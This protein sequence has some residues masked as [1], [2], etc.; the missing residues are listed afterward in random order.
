MGGGGS[1]PRPIQATSQ[2]QANHNKVIDQSRDSNSLLQFNWASFGSGVSS[3]TIIGVLLVLLFFC[4]RYNKRA[5][6]KQH[7]AQ[8]HEFAAITGHGPP[9]G[10][11][12]SSRNRYRDR[13]SYP[14]GSGYP[15]NPPP[16]GYSNGPGFPGSPPPGYSGYS[17]A[18]PFTA[19]PPSTIPGPHFGSLGYQPVPQ[20]PQFSTAQLSAALSSLGSMATLAAPSEDWHRLREVTHP[21]TRVTYQDELPESILRRPSSRRAAPVSRPASFH[22]AHESAQVHQANSAPASPGP[23]RAG[24]STMS[25]TVRAVLDRLEAEENAANQLQ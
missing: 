11:S 23:V 2:K 20:Q 13:D 7:E 6:R 21:R 22:S 18:A 17:G 16:S 10:A 8:L 14:G 9:P 25:P 24:N 15:G 19:A 5:N 12:R 1:K 3:V 4:W